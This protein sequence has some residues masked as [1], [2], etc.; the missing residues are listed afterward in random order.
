MFT[1]QKSKKGHSSGMTS[2]TKKKKKKV[3]FLFMLIPY[4]KFQD[5]ISNHS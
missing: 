4:I 1:M 5:T 3:R 2:P